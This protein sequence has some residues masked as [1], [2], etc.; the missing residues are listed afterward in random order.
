MARPF[1]T[2][3]YRDVETLEKAIDDYFDSCDGKP[4]IVDGIAV[5][6]KNGNPVF[7]PSKPYTLEG[8]A[9][10][11]G[12]GV[13]TLANYSDA[14]YPVN[15]CA[16]EEKGS[17]LQAID[18]ARAKC[19]NYNAER[20]FDKDGVQGAKFYA[21]NNSER[22]GGLKYAERQEVDMSIQPITFIDDLGDD[23]E[24]K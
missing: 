8:L 4:I 7:T 16:D 24:A 6:D 2:F 15:D 11:L 22:M 14:N 10:H 9:L 23:D 3:K 13:K 12:I 18:R 19:L 17:Y 20:L 5:T 1:G 21:I